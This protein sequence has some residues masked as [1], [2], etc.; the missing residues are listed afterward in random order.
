[1]YDSVKVTDAGNT[2]DVSKIE[3]TNPNKDFSLVENNGK[4]YI[5]YVPNGAVKRGKA[6]T[7]KFKVTFKDQAINRN[8]AKLSFK[9]NVA[10]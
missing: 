2:V 3:L 7:L 8:P 5:K 4:Y 1:M 6:Y 10:K 9:V